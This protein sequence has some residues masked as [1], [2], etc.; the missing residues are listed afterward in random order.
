V[1]IVSDLSNINYCQIV[2]YS[3]DPVIIH[4]N[5]K[6]IYINQAA[7]AFFKTTKE[8]V[9]GLSPLD[10]FQEFSKATIEKRIQSAYE[11]PMPVIEET[12]YRMDGTTVDI[13]LYCHPAPIG[14]QRAIQSIVWDITARKEMNTNKRKWKN[15]LTSYHQL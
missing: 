2:E 13:D 4:T 9:I 3:L 14:D 12:V 10:I 15:K 7:A 8:E 5:L 1:N 6:I 11:Q